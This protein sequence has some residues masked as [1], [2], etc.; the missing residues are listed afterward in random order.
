MNVVVLMKLIHDPKIT[1]LE[2]EVLNQRFGFYEEHLAYGP[3]DENALETALQ[4]RDQFGFDVT[5]VIMA[6]DVP[7]DMLRAPLAAGASRILYIPL[8]SWLFSPRQLARTLKGAIDQVQE[9]A[10]VL[11]GV[12]SGDWDTGFIPISLAAE[13]NAGYV[14]NLVDAQWA[15]E[16][17]TLTS[18]DASRSRT[19]KTDSLFVATVASSGHNTLRYPIMRDRL[20]A[21]RKPVTML[22]DLEVPQDSQRLSLSLEWVS[23]EAQATE[24][25]EADSDEEKGRLLVRR[26]QQ[27]GWLEEG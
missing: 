13:L 27:R 2:S 25:I 7:D 19:F 9:P 11:A 24:W 5:V 8:S 12:Q 14:P 17:W 16:A 6:Q 21:K 23:E 26:I 1:L 10:M 18:R 4:I 3:Y 15:D 22:S 20:Q